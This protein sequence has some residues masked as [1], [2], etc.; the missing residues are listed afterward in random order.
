MISEPMSFSH[1]QV[2]AFVVWEKKTVQ[3]RFVSVVV[4]VC[5]SRPLL[6]LLVHQE[7]IRFVRSLQAVL[8]VHNLSL[9]GYCE[10]DMLSLYGCGD[11]AG[12]RVLIV[13]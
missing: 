3:N 13:D 11:W 7:H 2:K 4:F 1:F 12:G 10:H 5:Y 8:N 9:A 6:T